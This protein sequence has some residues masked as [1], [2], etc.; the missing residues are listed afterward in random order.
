MPGVGGRGEQGLDFTPPANRCAGSLHSLQAIREGMRVSA[1][2]WITAPAEGARARGILM[3]AT[4]RRKTWEFL[5]FAEDGV[6]VLADT[7]SLSVSGPWVGVQVWESARESPGRTNPAALA[8]SPR[9]ASSAAQTTTY[10]R[11]SFMPGSSP[12][13]GTWNVHSRMEKNRDLS[14][15]LWSDG[16]TQS[17]DYLNH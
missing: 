4:G 11:R 17:I 6:S 9:H 14:H 13:A 3:R 5:N 12:D 1:W 10:V 16:V 15:S 7:D 8:V 2:S